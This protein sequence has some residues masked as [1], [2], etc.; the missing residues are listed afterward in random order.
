MK[1]VIATVINATRTKPVPS[2]KMARLSEI[3]FRGEKKRGS[4]NIILIGDTRMKTLNS[5][6]RRV[7][8]T[9]DVLSF[10]Y[11]DDEGDQPPSITGEIYIS[12][13]Q[14][15]KQAR[16]AGHELADELL[17][18]TSHGILHILGYTH[19]TTRKFNAMIDKQTR[20]LNILYGES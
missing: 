16:R 1:Q 3:I 7:N 11:D 10:S 9:T 15:A 14:A 5:K 2:R 13:P 12:V 6:Y 4:V 17:Y 19:E 8:K 18:L 20:Y